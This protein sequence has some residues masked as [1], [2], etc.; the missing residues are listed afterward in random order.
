MHT[1][2][3][4]IGLVLLLAGSTYATATGAYRWHLHTKAERLRAEGVPVQASV[5]GRE[6]T[7]GRGG[8]TDTI[9]VWYDV[10]GTQY[11]ERILCGS[12][13]GCTR[14]PPE[15]MTLWVDPERPEEFVAAN[16]NTDDSVFFLNSWGGIPFE[17]L[18]AALGAFFVFAALVP[19]GLFDRPAPASPR[20]GP[21]RNRI[22]RTRAARRRPRRTAR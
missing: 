3:A 22:R 12:A 18:V 15:V 10:D 2:G 13:G 4:V 17:L 21:G 1:G 6:N 7:V 20:R 5:T 19:T 11:T 14:E 8:G 9:R 16:G